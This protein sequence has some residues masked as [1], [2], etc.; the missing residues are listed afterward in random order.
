LLN[1]AGERTTRRWVVLPGHNNDVVDGAFSPEG[2]WLVIGQNK[3]TV[4]LWD[5]R[6]K[7]P[8]AQCITV[9]GHRNPVNAL[10][11]SSN[12]RWLITASSHP[13]DAARV[14]DLRAADPST[15][16]VGL[17]GHGWGI[18]RMVVSPDS[19]W[20]AIRHRDNAVR[21]WDLSRYHPGSGKF[22]DW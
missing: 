9:R 4:R 20:L 18:D 11:F 3:G 10:A 19:R 12:G 22:H 17:C 5:L 6:R 2:K 16:S 7:D 14:W 13:A 8:R 21:L 15:A 1:L